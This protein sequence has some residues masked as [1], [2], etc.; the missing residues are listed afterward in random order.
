MAAPIWPSCE[1]CA[2]S[3]RNAT[4][5]F[6]S[7]GFFSISSSTQAN[8][9]CVV[10]MIGLRSFR[11]RGRS[12]AFRA[13]PDDVFQVR[14]LL[15]VLADVR[16]ERFAVGQD[17]HDVDQLSFV[18]GLKRLCS[19][20]ASQQIE[21]V[22]PLP[23]EWLIRYLRPMSPVAAKCATA[24]SATLPHHAALV[25]AREDGEGGPLAACRPRRRAREHARGRT[26]ALP[27]TDPSTAPR[28]RGTRPGTRLRLC[29]ALVRPVLCQRKFSSRHGSVAAITSLVSAAR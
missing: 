5:S 10:T 20:S 24:S 11:K 28:G 19:R 9:C 7:S 4:R 1:R 22:L 21:S 29:G 13:R 12:S 15:D 17:E 3:I 26:T 18:P 8:F 27:A 2:S 6:F 14:E 16:V 25:I 23:A